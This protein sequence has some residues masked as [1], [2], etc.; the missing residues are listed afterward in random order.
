MVSAH[1]RCANSRAH[2]RTQAKP[3]AERADRTHLQRKPDFLPIEFLV[4]GGAITGLSAAIALSR[5][6]HKVTV[7]EHMPS[8]S[9]TPMGAG[10]R[11]PPNATKLYYR[12]GMQERLRSCSIK[13][14][15]VV[16]ARYDS[17][18]VVGVHD[19]EDGILEETGG[20]FLLM[21]YTDLR[22][23]LA[24]CAAEHGA[25]LRASCHVVD[26]HADPQRPY[27][28]LASGEV[29]TAD[30]IIGADGSHV[31][32]YRCRRVIL[33]ALGQEDVEKPTGMQLF[34]AILPG[35]AVDELGDPELLKQIRAGG[36]FTW[37]GPGHGAL[38]FPIKEPK[39]G[40]PLFTLYVYAPSDDQDIRVRLVDREV[41]L[42]ALE[43]RDSRL[44]KLAQHAKEV[45]LVPMVDRPYLDDWI[46]PRGRVIALGEAAH[47]IPVGSIYSLGMTACDAAVLGR[48]FAHLHRKDQ[49]D[50]FLNAIPEIRTPRIERVIRAATGNIFAVSLPPGVAEAR[51]R[52]LRERAERGIKEL[53]TGGMGAQTSEEMIQAIEGIFGYDPEDDADDWWVQWGLTQERAARMV[54]SDAVAVHVNENLEREE[55]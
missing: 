6:G 1:P 52:V 40:E 25:V 32:P 36:V 11:I 9:E 8:F 41:L 12:W 20:D 43:G 14:R 19:W 45:S 50:S 17:G 54:V 31:G 49:I 28:A 15:G 23:V 29:L 4:V 39:T 5:A 10:C 38:G 18:S 2:A 30:V 34:N 33:K 35:S 27:V 22:R 24:E 37:F 51:D 48:L 7:L 42:K 26:I 3:F 55:S 21:H 13:S 47:P 44:S 46:H 16:F 53:G